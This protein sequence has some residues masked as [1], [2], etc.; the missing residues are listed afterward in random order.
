MQSDRMFRKMDAAVLAQIDSGLTPK[1]YLKEG[2]SIMSDC[3]MLIENLKQGN[4]NNYVGKG[5]R[6]YGNTIESTIQDNEKNSS[7]HFSSIDRKRKSK[8]YKHRQVE[9]DNTGGSIGRA[10]ES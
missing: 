2:L 8:N 10:S 1:Q 4:Y 5:T 9:E 6:V 7:P 3:F